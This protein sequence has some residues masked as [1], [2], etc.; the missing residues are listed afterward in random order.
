MFV[1]AS[2]SPV[3][4]SFLPSLLLSSTPSS[5]LSSLWSAPP[6][7]HSSH[8]YA[9]VASAWFCVHGSARNSRRINFTLIVS[10]CLLVPQLFFLSSFLISTC[11]LCRPESSIFHSRLQ[12]FGEMF[13]LILTHKHSLFQWFAV[14]CTHTH[15]L[16]SW[17]S[18]ISHN[19]VSCVHANFLSLSKLSFFSMT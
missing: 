1:L 16:I 18:M 11:F 15:S 3:R 10:S 4:V 8:L 14:I 6:I 12:C 2:V 19:L 7:P 13:C 9:P 5:L 17:P